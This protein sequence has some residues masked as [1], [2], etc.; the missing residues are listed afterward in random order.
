LLSFPRDTA[1]YWAGTD[2]IGG[3]LRWD[4]LKEKYLSVNNSNLQ[5]GFGY[6]MISKLLTEVDLRNIA[7]SDTDETISIPLL[8][9]WN[10]IGIPVIFQ[11]GWWEAKMVVVENSVRPGKVWRKRPNREDGSVR[12]LLV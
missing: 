8:P 10:Q 12:Y 6:W 3:I 4:P 11:F 7:V 1:I 2:S 9:G 5:A